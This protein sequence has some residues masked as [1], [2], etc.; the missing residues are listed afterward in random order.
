MDLDEA[1]AKLRAA[2]LE[3]FMKVRDDLVKALREQG[4]VHLARLVAGTKKPD[5][6]AWAIG[7]VDASLRDALVIARGAAHAAQSHE[8]G[9][10]LR[11][12]LAEYHRAV[13]AVVSAAK[14]ILADAG[15]NASRANERAMHALLEGHAED[16]L[17]ALK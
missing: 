5:R 12:A 17:E 2:T 1:K 4:D 6:A 13:N 16:P 11:D 8:S 15:M 9:D 10:A 7:R 14:K 3:D